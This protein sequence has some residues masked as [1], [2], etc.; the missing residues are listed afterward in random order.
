MEIPSLEF[1]S[2][3]PRSGWNDKLALRNLLDIA[4]LVEQQF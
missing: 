4:A 2:F 3:I 1:T